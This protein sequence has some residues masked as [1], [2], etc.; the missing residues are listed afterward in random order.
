MVF[1]FICRTLS[2][3]RFRRHWLL[4]NKNI[5]SQTILQMSVAQREHYDRMAL[6]SVFIILLYRISSLPLED[7]QI[8]SRFAFIATVHLKK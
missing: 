3:F 7:F 8:R 5:T 6:K 1:N 4:V 2:Y